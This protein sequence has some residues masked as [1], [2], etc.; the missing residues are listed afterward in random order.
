MKLVWYANPA[1]SPILN[2]NCDA[3]FDYSIPP[4]VD[5]DVGGDAVDQG[6]VVAGGA[7]RCVIEADRCFAR[8]RNIGVVYA[9]ICEGH[10]V[11]ND[12]PSIKQGGLP[13]W[14]EFLGNGRK[15][16]ESTVR[17]VPFPT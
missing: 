2:R 6:I 13:K 9:R 5:F 14:R 8:V 4:A 17:W 7:A 10:E 12:D 3:A 16:A 15:V 1:P 11:T